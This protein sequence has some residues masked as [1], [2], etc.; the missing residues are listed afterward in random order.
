MRALNEQLKDTETEQ[1]VH[2]AMNNDQALSGVAQDISVAVKSGAITLDG[3][4][5]TEQQ[6]NLAGNT[7][8]AVGDGNKVNNRLEI[9]P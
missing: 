4:V 2:Q 7:A 3:E 5:A 1:Q 6:V 9:K 8:K